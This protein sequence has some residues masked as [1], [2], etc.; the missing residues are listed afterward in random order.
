[1]Q[2]E[3][4]VP[5]TFVSG[6]SGNILPLLIGVAII[7][8]ITGYL[9]RTGYT[10]ALDTATVTGSNL[11]STLETRLDAT[12]R[13]TDSILSGL[14]Y[15]LDEDKM[16]RKGSERYAS[17]IDNDLNRHAA[18][19]PELA[20]LRVFDSSGQ[21]L[22]T[23]ARDALIGRPHV[24]DRSFFLQLRDDPSLTRVFSE[25][26]L[27][28]S[29]G[30]HSIAV[31]YSVRNKEGQFLGIAIAL[32][33]L[34]YFQNYLRELDIGKH[35]TFA[36]RNTDNFGLVLRQPNIESELNQGLPPNNPARA[37]ISAGQQKVT[38]EF[39][40]K[41]DGVRRIF[42]LQRLQHH[43]YYALVAIAH[44]DALS[45]WYTRA[46][47][48]LGS[49]FILLILLAYQQR[50]VQRSEQ[51][52]KSS[53]SALQRSEQF[54]TTTIDA[55]PDQICV[56][57]R[58]GRI[59][60]VNKSWRDFCEQNHLDA[61]NFNYA[62]DC[63]YLDICRAGSF[64][65][66]DKATLIE[67]GIRKVASGELPSF[68]ME[69]PC[70][71]P[72]KNGYFITR[73]SRF[74]GDSG[75]LLIRHAN[76]TESKKAE[77]ELTLLASIFSNSNEAIT[78]TDARNQIIATNPAFTALTGYS[79]EEVIGKNPKILSAGKT[80]SEFYKEM[81]DSIH[82][83]G[84]W[85]GELW[86]RRKS[87]EPYPKWLSISVVRGN[88]GQIVNF[89]GSFIDITERK[90]SE[91]KIRHLAYH[92]ALTMLPNRFSFQERL[93]QAIGFSRRNGK[94]LALMLIDLDRFKSINDTLGHH[95]GDEILIQVAQRISA[96]VRQSDIVARLGGDEF[97]VVLPDIAS[98]EDA[99]RVAKKIIGAICDPYF[100]GGQ[101]LSSSPSIGI[102]LYPDDASEI[103]DLLKNADVAMYEAKAQGRSNYQ[104]F[105]E[106]MTI[107]TT[108][109]MALE[110]DL[111]LA[112]AKGQFILYY[113]PQ[114]SLQDRTLVGVEALIRWDHPTRGIV[115]PLEFIPI[116]EETGLILP[117]GDW[118]LQE[119]CQQLFQWRA[120]G[121]DHIRISVNL[122]AVQFLDK[123]LPDRV[124]ALLDQYSLS[125][126]LLD[127]EVTESMTMSAPQDA[128]A[129]MSKL[130][131]K[132][133]T[134][135]V[136]DF[137]TGYSSLAYL[138][139][140]PIST[141]KI[142]RS[143]VKDI[144]T[145]SNDAEICDV[146]VLLAHK[147]GLDVVAEGVETA[148]QLK[149]LL[150]IGCEKIQGYLISKPL[151]ARE[152]EKFIRDNPTVPRIGTIELWTPELSPE[153]L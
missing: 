61:L 127:L 124:H 122:S 56:I 107:E 15:V 104:F 59:L 143:F 63:N 129:A 145:D 87:G 149:F 144:E 139:L 11:A 101:T 82:Q 36:I 131:Q 55:V 77:S 120:N 46:R 116:A 79:Q 67:E 81:W 20:G 112:L 28:R 8:G 48:T 150:S 1:M 33:N 92:D 66:A 75:N 100:I 142:D 6:G 153:H 14:V 62:I 94:Q 13:R 85:Q 108:K 135:S 16:S 71:T 41:T 109:R 57:D 73:I 3:S 50:R 29:T 72:V 97:V 125:T 141:L 88:N 106:S 52:L 49:L 96:S 130:T 78:I 58:D 69:Y 137:G 12:L 26:F 22:Y 83:Y 35:G 51:S 38:V 102:C 5:S 105:T 132:G 53:L 76:I 31:A 152:V 136:D 138:K 37:L 40:A 21:L 39:E 9:L 91:E 47:L 114:L 45:A 103:S 134:L 10:D 18:H 123:G 89:I 119:A 121:I 86:D 64:E 147:L 133:L 70:N 68:E 23:N 25:T 7:L 32:I 95:I 42:S 43:P 90:A 128:I 74:H 126:D 27:V 80:S 24:E 34:D 110:A 44:E 4:K 54:V 98:P 117:I 113:Q 118:V 111:R 30:T 146:T 17:K 115:S 2:S 99:A 140:F 148:A 84:K 65:N 60:A 151:P 19:F 93:E